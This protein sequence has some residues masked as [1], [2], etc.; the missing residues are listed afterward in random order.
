MGGAEAL[1]DEHVEVLP[2]HRAAGPA[3][4]A[5]GGGVELDH[6]LA[7]VHGDDGVHGGLDDA[8][9]ARLDALQRAV[10]L[11]ALGDLPIEQ[12]DGREGGKAADSRGDDH[13]QVAVEAEEGGG[14]RG[15]RGR[16]GEDDHRRE[17]DREPPRGKGRQDRLRATR[18]ASDSR[19]FHHGF[20]GNQS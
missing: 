8:A 16:R 4:D 2:H 3:E 14:G 13:H 1:G 9:H 15:D 5:L 17:E 12:E 10:H 6:A 18:G 11:L 7:L 20:D 19:G